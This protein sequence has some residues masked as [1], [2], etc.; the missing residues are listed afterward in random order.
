MKI[1]QDF[2]IYNPHKENLLQINM[3]KYDI[4]KVNKNKNVPRFY[5]TLLFKYRRI[6]S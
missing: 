3:N 1:D 4:D 5:C 6:D 2:D